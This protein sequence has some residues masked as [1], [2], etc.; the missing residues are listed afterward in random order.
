MCLP[1][2]RHH[3]R[4]LP[5]D[6]STASERVAFNAASMA[7]RD[8]GTGDP[9]HWQCRVT[10]VMT[11]AAMLGIGGAN[12]QRENLGD[13]PHGAHPY[14]AST[15]LG[16]Y[17]G[18]QLGA[19]NAGTKRSQPVDALGHGQRQQSGTRGTRGSARH[20]RRTRRASKPAR[21][22]RNSLAPRS[23]RAQTR[24]CAGTSGARTAAAAPCA[25]VAWPWVPAPAWPGRQR[26][27][28]WATRRWRVSV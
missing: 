4:H 10:T 26:G 6:A 2:S 18:V 12:Q 24:T 5:T 14:R 17:S 20:H 16:R 27:P 23:P 25:A 15:S 9:Q 22:D 19:Q 8:T 21:N 7:S 3:A 1:L 13:R 28:C 11:A